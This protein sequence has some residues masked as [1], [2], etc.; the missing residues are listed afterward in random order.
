LQR[1]RVQECQLRGQDGVALNMKK[2][3]QRRKTRGNRY[4]TLLPE[5][6]G[7]KPRRATVKGAKHPLKSAEMIQIKNGLSLTATKTGK[8]NPSVS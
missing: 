6:K 8:K 3:K 4:G 1:R 5:W 7:G 2:T